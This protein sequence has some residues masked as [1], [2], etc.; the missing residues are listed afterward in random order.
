MPEE[1]AAA[2]DV[3]ELGRARSWVVGPTVI[4]V[5]TLAAGGIGGYLLGGATSA[6]DV[7]ENGQIAYAC[8][9]AEKV[10]E[11]HQTEDDWGPVDED[12][13]YGQASVIPALLGVT[14]PQRGG[15]RFADLGW[16]GLWQADDLDIGEVLDATIEAC[17]NG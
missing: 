11:S 3:V 1:Q 14:G 7:S 9:L 2:P 4:A 10:R 6:P 17:A 15:E 5:V 8:A 16:H 12:P 13:A